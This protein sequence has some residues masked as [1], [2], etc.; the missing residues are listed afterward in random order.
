MRREESEIAGDKIAP[1]EQAV[2]NVYCPALLCFIYKDG[3]FAVK[4]FVS[5]LSIEYSFK[6]PLCNSVSFALICIGFSTVHTTQMVERGLLHLVYSTCKYVDSM[7][8][9]LLL[10]FFFPVCKYGSFFAICIHFEVIFT[11][12]NN[13]HNVVVHLT[14][15]TLYYPY[16]LCHC[17][18]TLLSIHK[19]S[20]DWLPQLFVSRVNRCGD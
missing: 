16:P 12:F 20:E 9:F 18:S 11:C 13:L 4:H 10:L 19:L 15:A 7:E 6:E 3:K 5:L 17:F 2:I 8:L 1:A 14:S